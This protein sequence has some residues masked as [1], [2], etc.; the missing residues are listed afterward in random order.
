MQGKK[1]ILRWTSTLDLQVDDTS[2]L[3]P[4]KTQC[5]PKEMNR[6]QNYEA[7]TQQ[8]NHPQKM[9]FSNLWTVSQ[10]I[11]NFSQRE[12]GGIITL[13]HHVALMAVVVVFYLSDMGETVT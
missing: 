12:R 10:K 8:K 13:W 4:K 2:L 9:Q 7:F 5:P 3:L 1:K 6:S 11:R